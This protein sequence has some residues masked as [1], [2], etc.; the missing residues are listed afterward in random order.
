[1]PDALTDAEAR[2]A[3]LET[4]LKSYIPGT[5]MW[6][7]AKGEVDEQRAIVDR[8]RSTPSGPRAGGEHAQSGQHPPGSNQAGTGQPFIPQPAPPSPGGAA[9]QGQ[10]FIPQPAASPA[11]PA[12]PGGG[13]GS[14]A[15]GGGAASGGG[16]GGGGGSTSKTP[17]DID[18]IMKD[19]REKYS[20]LTWAFDNPELGPLWARAQQEAWDANRWRSELFKTKWF[21]NHALQNATDSLRK[22]SDSYLVP[23]SDTVLK[24]YAY[25]IATGEIQAAEFRN[26]MKEQAKGLWGDFGGALDRGLTVETIADS[27]RQR[28]A[29]ELDLAPQTID[30]KDAKW[31]RLISKRDPET[32]RIVNPT[33]SDALVEVRTSS[34][35][36]WDFSTTGRQTRARL[37]TDLAKDFG[38]VG[39]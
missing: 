16:G 5:P 2:L 22:V 9:G 26:Q 18:A 11:Q 28:V 27:Y 14:T 25:S 12:Q 17:A 39:R 3:T 32:N 38:M 36:G 1:M 15:A 31:Q 20:Y 21:R 34:E 10:P 30:F 35:Y 4:V 7:Q 19:A 37:F 6:M 13:G 8:L 29:Q 23:L 24:D 33:I